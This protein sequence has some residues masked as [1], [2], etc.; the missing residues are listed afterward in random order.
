MTR[1]DA[2]GA[3]QEGG[4]TVPERQLLPQRLDRASLLKH[5]FADTILKAREKT[6]PLKNAG[7]DPDKLKREKEEL[8]RLQR[9]KKAR[10]HAEAKLAE[11]VRRK[12][13]A[14]VAAKARCQREAE[15]QAARQ[16]LEQVEKTVG[17]SENF[18]LLKDLE[19]LGRASLG[20]P[21]VSRSAEDASNCA[22]LQEHPLEQLG[23][24]M[25][26]DDDHFF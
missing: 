20:H 26:V 6:L 16:A 17:Q 24:F 14:A 25:K 12:A 2:T 10:L 13:E 11:E 23:L 18:D 19:M 4:V 1:G 5:R 21:S 8:E 15:R 22:C 3:T 9:E 7:A